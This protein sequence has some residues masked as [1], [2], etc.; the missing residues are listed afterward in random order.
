MCLQSFVLPT[1]VRIFSSACPYLVDTTLPPLCAAISSSKDVETVATNTPRPYSVD[2]TAQTD[3][4]AGKVRHNIG[5][6]VTMT[7]EQIARRWAREHGFYLARSETLRSTFFHHLMS[8]LRRPAGRA[9]KAGSQQSTFSLPICDLEPLLNVLAR[10]QK[11]PN[12]VYAVEDGEITWRKSERKTTYYIDD[13][14]I[15]ADFCALHRRGLESSIPLYQSTKGVAATGENGNGYT[16]IKTVVMM[17]PPLIIEHCHRSYSREVLEV[18]FNTMTL[19]DLDGLKLPPH[20]AYA[21]GSDL[22]FK[23]LALQHVRG[24]RRE[25]HSVSK[26]FVQ[27][28]R[29]HQ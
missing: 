27:L 26:L 14:E 11:F 18:S 2:A 28:C 9:D 10:C 22:L 4:Y 24:L 15:L 23:Q 20:F 6:Q 12:K 7:D 3:D 13:V 8:C 25:G 21:P 17:L 16:E 5:T 19:N 1:R 29:K